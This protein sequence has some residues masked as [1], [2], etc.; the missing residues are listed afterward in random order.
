LDF[1]R[2]T[3]T[4]L[5]F[6]KGTEIQPIWTP[7]GKRIV[8]SSSREAP[9]GI[10]WKSADGTGEVEKLAS[11]ADRQL[12][13]YSWSSDG[14]T[15]VTAEMVTLTNLDIGTLSME[16]DRTRK[17]LL[18]TEYIESMPQIS[19]DGRWMAYTSNEAIGVPLK[20]DIYVRP[21]PEVNKGKW[22]VSTGGGSCPLW[23]P[24]GRELFY[25]SDDACIM[26]VQVETKPTL[27]FG[28]PKKLFKNT[29]LG[30]TWAEG[31]PWDIS[32]DGKRFL[33][34]KLPASTGALSAAAAPRPKI[35][36]VLNWFEELKQ[37]VPV[38]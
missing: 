16:G 14:K 26:A 38:K 13:P 1:G 30:L 24:D 2:K 34:I 4:K 33:M 9:N 10:Y 5:T 31:T 28:T 27:S 20:G 32:R 25:L 35:N 15:L 36:I 18:Q 29:Y 37:R 23:A 22:Q 6:E 19:P 3:L 21:F 17:P 11:A 12:L 7:D 8:Y